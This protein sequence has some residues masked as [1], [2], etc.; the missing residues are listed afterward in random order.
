[1]IA[2][3]GGR[4]QMGK[5]IACPIY[6]RMNVQTAAEL[7]ALA[8]EGGRAKAAHCTLQYITVPHSDLRLLALVLTGPP[9]H[10]SSL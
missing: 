10:A 3:K 8:R 2:T 6:K 5:V 4:L 9:L 7:S 1:M